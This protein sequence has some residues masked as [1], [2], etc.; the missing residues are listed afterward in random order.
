MSNLSSPPGPNS[1]RRRSQRVML[2]V[3]VTVLG[4]TA[5]GQFSENTHTMVISPHGALVGLKAKVTQGQTVRL[6]SV[7]SPEEQECQVIWVG[8]TAEGKAQLGLEFTKPAP[9]FW[10]VSFPSADWSPAKA[11]ATPESRQK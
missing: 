4:K 3:P 1:N 9:K 11:K 6:K 10:G 7:T 2:S 5:Q 8:P